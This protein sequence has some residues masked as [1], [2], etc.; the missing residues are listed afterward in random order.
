MNEFRLSTALHF[1]SA[2]LTA[3]FYMQG[4]TTCAYIALLSQVGENIACRL[5]QNLFK[6]F[7]HQ[8]VSF[9]DE[10]KTGELIDRLTSDVQASA[11]CLR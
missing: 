4:V 5:R 10:H 3:R 6:S 11:E 8:D 7:L 2:L 1:A 9:Y